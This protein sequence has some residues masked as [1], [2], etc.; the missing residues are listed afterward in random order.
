[1][2]YN[3]ILGSAYLFQDRKKGVREMKKI[4]LKIMTYT[5]VL[6]CFLYLKK[7]SQDFWE[8]TSIYIHVRTPSTSFACKKQALGYMETSDVSISVLSFHHASQPSV[9]RP[10]RRDTPGNVHTS[11]HLS[12][13]TIVS[14]LCSGALTA[15]RLQDRSNRCKQLT[16]TN[17]NAE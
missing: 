13:Q 10:H 3:W 8:N 12:L 7:P 9:H 4:L 1:M 16:L 6:K 14:F 5:S 17:I 15:A 11:A 2:K